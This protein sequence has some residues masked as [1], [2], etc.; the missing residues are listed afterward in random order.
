MQY[1]IT[2]FLIPYFLS[3]S[4]NKCLCTLINNL[5]VLCIVLKFTNCKYIYGIYD[6][7]LLSEAEKLLCIYILL[8]KLKGE[9]EL[10]FYSLCPIPLQYIN[11]QKCPK[12]K[13]KI[14]IGRAHV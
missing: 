7:N 10:C 4:L 11:Q 8:Y 13:V 14:E 5:G 9:A 2:Y 12:S 1:K 3:N 6:T